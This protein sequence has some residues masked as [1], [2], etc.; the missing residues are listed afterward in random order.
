M[1]MEHFLG[2]LVETN[3]LEKI[4]HINGDGTPNMKHKNNRDMYH[5]YLYR[6]IPSF[7]C[8]ICMENVENSGC[9][10]KCGHCFCVDCF[11][12]LARIG[13]KCAL[14]R[15]NLSE[16]NVKKE[17]DQNTLIDIVN[18]ELETPYADR[19]NKNICEYIYDQVKNLIESDNHNDTIIAHAADTIAMEVFD[20]LH[21]VAYVTMETMNN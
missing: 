10:L 15:R 12:N 20:S 3:Q 21:M 4:T 18:Y 9:K 1:D 7:E 8:S 6:R 14:C 17:V 11:S 16:T 19:G 13:N 5:E 2:Y